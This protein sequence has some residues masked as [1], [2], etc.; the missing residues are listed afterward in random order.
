LI[1]ITTVLGAA[2]FLPGAAIA[3]DALLA[4]TI[5]SAAGEKMGGVAVSAKADGATITTTVYTDEAGS[6]YFP[7]MATAKYR[8]W[9]QAVT[10]ETAKGNVELTATRHQDFVM[11]PMTNKEDW[12]RQLPG[13]EILAAL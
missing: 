7:P 13:D 5:T 4:G 8:V 10:Y 12:I 9:A 2:A 3:A 1:A 11:K 6:Y